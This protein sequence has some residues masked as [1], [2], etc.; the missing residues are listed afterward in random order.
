MLP[1]FQDQIPT[2]DVP[3][4]SLV[5]YRFA[6]P[7]VDWCIKAVLGQFLNQVDPS[8]W[9]KVGT[10]TV[11]DAAE[12]ATRVYESLQ[13]TNPI[14]SIIPYATSLPTTP[15]ILVCDGAS[16]LRADYIDLFLLI[17]TTWGSVDSLHFNVPDLRGRAIIGAGTGA[18]LTTRVLGQSLGEETHVLTTAEL[19]AH[20]H[21][22]T[23]HAHSIPLVSNLLTGTPPP[24]DAAAVVP[25]ITAATGAAAA[26]LTNTGSDSPHNNMQPS[27]V[28][29]W[30]I[31]A[32]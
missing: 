20:T 32:L 19:A 7:D 24:L 28:I 27:A 31:Q 17:G 21:T 10:A 14:G 15:S 13:M 11:D 30:G 29:V 25:V 5:Y 2:G 23:G 4:T 9:V 3:P 26:N 6:V 1:S 8:S 22:D 16:Y 12:M 18:G